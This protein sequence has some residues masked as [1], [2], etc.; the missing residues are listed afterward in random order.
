MKLN[1]ELPINSLSFGQFSYGIL[2]ELFARQYLPN[3]FP[4]GNV[5]LNAYDLDKPFVD[6]LQFC[7]NRAPLSY[8]RNIPTL[9]FWHLNGSERRLSDFQILWTPHETTDFTPT[10]K[11]IIKN[12]DL[13]LFPSKY[14][15]ENAKKAGL[16]NVDYSPNFFDH[17]HFKR[18]DNIVRPDAITFTLIG[19]FEKRKHTAQILQLWSK[20]YGK[21]ADY[22][23]NCLINNPFIPQENFN[24]IIGQIFQGSV[25]WNINF[26]PH[27]EKNSQVNLIMNA[28][29]IDLSGLSGAE[30]FNLPCFHMLALNKIGVVLDAHAHKD[31][32]SMGNSVL[33]EPNGLAPIYDGHFFVQGAPFNQGNMY[34]FDQDLA[35][36]KIEEAVERF[37]NGD[38]VSTDLSNEFGVKNV[39]DRLL[40]FI[41]KS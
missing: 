38:I 16:T 27:Q 8:N 15:L 24:K 2:R 4:I 28:S 12:S 9:R 18:V 39:V 7:I 29:D 41:P 6:W 21:N 14:S 1:I 10:E 19:K 36:S 30:G 13:V 22:R 40:S 17:F 37:K 20:M 34:I 32:A 5:E 23:L 33:V 26:L 31:Y 35:A 11:N 3:V 25:P